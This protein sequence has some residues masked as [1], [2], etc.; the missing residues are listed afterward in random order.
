M[1]CRT[2]HV[3]AINAREGWAHRSMTMD[4]WTFCHRWA[5]MIWMSEI[6]S[7]GILPAP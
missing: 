3:H 7:V 4:S 1:K 6:F 5:R 2:H